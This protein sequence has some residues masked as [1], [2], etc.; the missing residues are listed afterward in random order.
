MGFYNFD[1]LV[2]KDI[3]LKLYFPKRTQTLWR[4]YVQF[5][6]NVSIVPSHWKLFCSWHTANIHG[7][8]VVDKVMTSVKG[9]TL[10]SAVTMRAKLNRDGVMDLDTYQN[11][12]RTVAEAP[13]LLN[14]EVGTVDRQTAFDETHIWGFYW[15][16][17]TAKNSITLNSDSHVLLRD[18]L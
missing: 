10:A 12:A 11:W 9:G 18:N 3:L 13:A 16:F 14:S 2:K 8:A 1:M 5:Y 6:T 17:P 4:V 7:K 15:N